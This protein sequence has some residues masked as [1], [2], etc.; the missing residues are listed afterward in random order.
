[1][2]PNANKIL[3][4]LLYIFHANISLLLLH[5]IKANMHTVLSSQLSSKSIAQHLEQKF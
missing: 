5:K 4:C 3:A 1:M 2:S